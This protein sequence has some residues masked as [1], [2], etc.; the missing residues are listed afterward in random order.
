MASSS[1][2]QGIL[3]SLIV[4]VVLT[5]IMSVV[6]FLF[7]QENTKL[8]TQRDTANTEKSNAEKAKSD[9][10][11]VRDALRAKIG[12]TDLEYG[13]DDVNSPL[14]LKINEELNKYADPAN[15]TYTQALTRVNDSKDKSDQLLQQ[16]TDD[17][18]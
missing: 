13:T 17:Y 11:R 18:A 9:A 5:V 3:I 7:Y 4:F 10:F 1:K 15:L 2:G 16:K 8:T 12:Y 6:S 14:F